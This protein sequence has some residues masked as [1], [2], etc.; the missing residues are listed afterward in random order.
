MKKSRNYSS[1]QLYTSNPSARD[2]V[3]KELR[4]LKMITTHVVVPYHLLLST[5]RY[6]ETVKVTEARQYRSRCLIHVSDAFF[7]TR[8][9]SM[10][11]KTILI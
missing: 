1:E 6:P 7:D 8:S 5:T 2:R 4:K 3:N 11:K 10:L 9:V